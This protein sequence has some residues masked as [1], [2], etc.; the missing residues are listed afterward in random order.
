MVMVDPWSEALAAI[1]SP[2]GMPPTDTS[3]D[4]KKLFDA[5]G[6][7]YDRTQVIGDLTG[8]WLVR[9]GGED[10]MQAVNYV[11][12]FNI[13]DGINHDDPATADLTQITVAAPGAIW[14]KLPNATIEFTPLL[15]TSDALRSLSRA[16][17]W[18]CRIRRKFLA[19]LSRKVDHG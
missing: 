6:I 4:L 11:A 15:S 12:W 10:R 19:I 3:S 9:G 2:T 7:V 16:I 8:A 17:N 18:R 14:P 5:W 13:R 1:P